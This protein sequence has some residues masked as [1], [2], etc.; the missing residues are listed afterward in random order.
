MIYTAL[1]LKGEF[2]IRAK[3]SK[4]ETGLLDTGLSLLLPQTGAF[5]LIW[6]KRR[7]VGGGGIGS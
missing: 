1:G 2:H 6:G 7:R 3:E 4:S 5:R